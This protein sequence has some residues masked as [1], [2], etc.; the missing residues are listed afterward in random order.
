VTI[1]IVDTSAFCNVL[2]IPGKNQH[3]EEARA[4]LRAFI[5]EGAG[6]L[7]PLAAV[8]ETARHIA[9][10][11]SGGQRRTTAERFVN[12]VRLALNGEAPW[13]PTPLPA[14]PDLADWLTEFPDAA[15][16]RQ[17]LADLSM[18]KLWKQ[19]CA[20]HRG[21]RVLIW[22]YDDTDLGGYDRAGGATPR[23]SRH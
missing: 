8:Y 2:D 5:D 15:T 11:A 7:L 14:Q 9:Q 19:Q 17:S 6:L 23:R 13:A 12:Q 1:C 4:K 16:R 22:T 3:R 21:R 18:I 20:R 10:L